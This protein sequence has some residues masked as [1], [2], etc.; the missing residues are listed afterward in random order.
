MSGKHIVIVDDNKGIRESLEEFL[1][2]LCKNSGIQMHVASEPRIAF[3]KIQK[4]KK[5]Y[6]SD[7]LLITDLIFPQASDDGLDLM[8]LVTEKYKNQ[9]PFIVLLTAATDLANERVKKAW[10]LADEVKIKSSG[11]FEVKIVVK[12]YFNCPEMDRLEKILPDYG[13]IN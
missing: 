10:D 7:I 9:R 5:N 6:Q 2:K 12:N 8:M 11:I 1:Y 4:L 3:E 13:R